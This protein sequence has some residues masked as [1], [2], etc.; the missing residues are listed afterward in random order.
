MNL[1]LI[2]HM[3]DDAL[4]GRIGVYD[5]PCE[6]PQCVTMEA[7]VPGSLLACLVE[8]MVHGIASKRYSC[9]PREYDGM[10]VLFEREGVKIAIGNSAR[11]YVPRGNI[12]LDMSSYRRDS[13]SLAEVEARLGIEDIE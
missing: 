1:E 7:Q 10:L 8:Y 11:F 12:R 6:G 13:L 5:D 2:V 9:A 4:S 3:E